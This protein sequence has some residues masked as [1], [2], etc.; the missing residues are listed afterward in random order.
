M[1]LP[2]TR[3]LQEGGERCI[4]HRLECLDR[5]N[6]IFDSQRFAGNAPV[7]YS[8]F[9]PKQ[10]VFKF[11]FWEWVNGGDGTGG[12]PAGEVLMAER[13]FREYLRWHARWRE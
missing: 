9:A 3:Y 4:V 1:R 12:G 7:V 6:P 5:G 8:S 13:E 10:M 11:D 2:Y